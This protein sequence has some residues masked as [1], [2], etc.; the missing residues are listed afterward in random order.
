M[1]KYIKGYVDLSAYDFR[2]VPSILNDVSIE[3]ILNIA[4]NGIKNLNFIHGSSVTLG[5]NKITDFK[6]FKD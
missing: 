2:E 3:G 6:G 4:D 1:G 5:I